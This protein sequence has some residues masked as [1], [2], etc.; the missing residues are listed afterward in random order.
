[1]LNIAL[2]QEEIGISLLFFGMKVCSHQNCLIEV[3][4]VSTHNIQLSIYI[5]IYIKKR[6]SNEI[7]PNKITSAAMG[8]LLLGT[9][10]PV[11]NNHGK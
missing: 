4:L 5:Y 3:I 9:Q 2:G 10:E 8:F 1:M 7:I 11:Q 6:K